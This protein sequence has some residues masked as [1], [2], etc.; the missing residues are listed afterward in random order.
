MSDHRNNCIDLSKIK[1]LNIYGD[2]YI[3]QATVKNR[4]QCLNISSGK[5]CVVESV[6]K[7]YSETIS[8]KVWIL[9]IDN[10]INNK[11]YGPLSLRYIFP[12]KINE[13][14]MEQSIIL[15][16]EGPY[17]FQHSKHCW[18]S[19]SNRYL[20]GGVMGKG[21]VQE[22]IHIITM[23]PQLLFLI[24][25]N[26]ITGTLDLYPRLD[27]FTINTILK[28]NSY[29]GQIGLQKL[30]KEVKDMKSCNNIITKV[31]NIDVGWL[32]SALPNR[33]RSK[34]TPYAPSEIEIIFNI[35]IKSSILAIKSNS[36]AYHTGAHGCGAYGHNVR[37]IYLLQR[38]AWNVA[39]YIMGKHMIMYWHYIDNKIKRDVME[40]QIWWDK[41]YVG[42]A[43][44]LY[45]QIEKMANVDIL[46]Y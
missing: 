2:C 32:S 21:F 8:W 6:L 46:F 15:L 36:V 31:L 7:N 37:T 43:K 16:E 12:L 1:L 26:N 23:F 20:G 42:D 45:T 27:F 39:N 25:D 5:R 34:G 3:Y 19:F 22:E 44:V 9:F 40:A 17:K 28:D 41:N 4:P 11:Y 18:Q 29:Y 10:K 14:P 13:S 38:L 24:Q 30:E 33:Q 35:L